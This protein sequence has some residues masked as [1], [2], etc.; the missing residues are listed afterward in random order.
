MENDR[1]KKKRLLIDVSQE[2]HKEVKAR[3]VFRGLS[4]R[5]WVEMAIKE[6]IREERQYEK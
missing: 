6:R 4:I 3:A 1:P 2:L 5:Q